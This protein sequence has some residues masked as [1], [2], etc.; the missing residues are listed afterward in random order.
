MILVGAIP[1]REEKKKKKFRDCIVSKVFLNLGFQGL[2]V[3]G[4]KAEKEFYFLDVL[5]H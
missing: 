4:L 1:P 2:K 3:V 5:A